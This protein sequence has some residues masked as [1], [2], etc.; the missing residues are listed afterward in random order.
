MNYTP[1]TMVVVAMT[2]PQIH[3]G[4]GLVERWGSGVPQ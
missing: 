2:Y 1:R 3:L 4:L